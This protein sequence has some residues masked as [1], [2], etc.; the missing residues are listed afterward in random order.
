MKNARKYKLAMCGT[1]NV[2]KQVIVAVKKCC[3]QLEVY[4]CA[5]R[6]INN[7]HK[8]AE[9]FKIIRVFSSYDELFACND[10]DIIY[11]STPTEVH[12]EHIKKS[13]MHNK[14]IICE[15]PLCCNYEEAKEL[16]E[17]AKN[18]GLLLI[19]AIW[20]MYMPFTSFIREIITKNELGNVRK[21]HSSFGYPELD[22]ARLTNSR[23]G[24]SLLDK[25]V[26][27]IALTLLCIGDDIKEINTKIRYINTVD[28]TT[29]AKIKY[30]K[31]VA[32]IHSSIAHRT[33][34]LLYIRL[35]KGILISRKFWMGKKIIYWKFP[36]SIKMIDFSH[37]ANGYEYEFEEIIYCLENGLV[38]SK[39]F[40]YEN[41][42][43]IMKLMDRIKGGGEQ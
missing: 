2:A 27:C 32:T 16:I 9:K 28:Q 20:T 24:G 3:P 15:K 40:P 39:V 43:K 1:G 30:E 7:A 11:I 18:K 17:I 41:T 22:M 5:S 34:Y 26:Y 35:S 19:D 10:V 14:N 31:C 6:D 37:K 29:R 21:V 33:L 12:Y 42:L 38:E 8:F 23:G 25:G 4:G 13:L 36:F